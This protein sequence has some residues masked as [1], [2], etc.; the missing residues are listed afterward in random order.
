MSVQRAG[1]VARVR[2]RYE[3]LP[4][5]GPARKTGDLTPDPGGDA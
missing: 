4:T 1:I 3:E 2:R 5:S